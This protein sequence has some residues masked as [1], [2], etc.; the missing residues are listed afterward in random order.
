MKRLISV[1]LAMVMT[2]SL[3]ACTSAQAKWQKQYDLGLKYVSEAKYD[4]AVISFNK[5]IEID[6]KQPQAYVALAGVQ[7]SYVGGGSAAALETI[8]KA[9]EA[10]GGS[11][12]L[13]MVREQI[14]NTTFAYGPVLDRMAAECAIVKTETEPGDFG[15]TKQISYD[16]NGNPV[17]VSYT[18][19]DGNPR[20]YFAYRYNRDNQRTRETAYFAGEFLRYTLYEYDSQGRAVKNTLQS[21]DGAVSGTVII[22]YNAD[23]RRTETNYGLSGE[24]LMVT[25]YDAQGRKTKDAFY[26]N[27]ALKNYYLH[28]YSDDGLTR[29]TTHGGDGYSVL[30]AKAKLNPNGTVRLEMMFTPEGGVLSVTDEKGSYSALEYIVES[31]NPVKSE[32]EPYA[33]GGKKQIYYDSND[34]PVAELRTLSSVHGG[35]QDL[36]LY[37]YNRDIRVFRELPFVPQKL[38]GEHQ[39]SLLYLS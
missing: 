6:P 19:R 32:T 9:I 39:H 23:G 17:V 21:A 4:E 20:E 18:D 10:T 5:A 16:A 22:E 2:L 36:S 1:I 12:T 30:H 26:E 37:T 7:Y 38:H 14:E 25:E 35:D 13:Q 11:D 24:K 8:D 29:T 3:A 27:N 33:Y 31:L 34:N 28:E 15:G